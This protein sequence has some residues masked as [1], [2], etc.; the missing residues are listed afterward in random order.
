MQFQALFKSC[1][2]LC[3]TFITCQHL[4]SNNVQFSLNLLKLS[5]FKI[6]SL[7]SNNSKNIKARK[8]EC[9]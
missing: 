7:T 9:I 1:K 4:S 6:K 2:V 8:N 3:N 5:I